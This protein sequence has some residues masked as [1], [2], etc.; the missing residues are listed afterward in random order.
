MPDSGDDID[1]A[2]RNTE[3]KTEQNEEQKGKVAVNEGKR[4]R[5]IAAAKTQAQIRAVMALLQDDLKECGDGMERGEC[6]QSE[7]DKVHA[8]T[9]AAQKRM[10]EVGNKEAT[11]EEEMSFQMAGLL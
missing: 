6:D 7:V 1:Q 11:P 5:Q 10:G 9:A 4:M 8:L 3:K 2:D